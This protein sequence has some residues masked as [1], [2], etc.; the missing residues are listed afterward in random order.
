MSFLFSKQIFP[1]IFIWTRFQISLFTLKTY[2]TKKFVRVA[3]LTSLLIRCGLCFIFNWSNGSQVVKSL[4][5]GKNLAKKCCKSSCAK[6]DQLP[7][8]VGDS[9]W[10]KSR[11][12]LTGSW[13][14][15][16]NGSKTGTFVP[17]GLTKNNLC[18]YIFIQ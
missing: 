16:C 11:C 4:I 5:N 17:S 14:G 13:D 2:A 8:P 12:G 6:N 15:L 1:K 9:W 18:S 10:L 3:V 7:N